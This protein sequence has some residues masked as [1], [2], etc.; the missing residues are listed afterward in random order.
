M[1]SILL[2]SSIGSIPV[3]G[4]TV[5]PEPYDSVALSVAATATFWNRK[6]A[7][8]DRMLIACSNQR[9][10]KEHWSA[11]SSLCYIQDVALQKISFLTRISIKAEQSTS[12]FRRAPDTKFEEHISILYVNPSIRVSVLKTA[13]FLIVTAFRMPSGNT[14]LSYKISHVWK[15]D[16]RMT[17]GSIGHCNRCEVIW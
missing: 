17:H 6:Q 4:C 9:R 3:T 11:F 8:W 15:L 13:S 14:T 10:M 7:F 2:E 1:E 16:L 12:T 5:L